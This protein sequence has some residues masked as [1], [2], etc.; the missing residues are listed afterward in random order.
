LKEQIAAATDP[1]VIETLEQKIKLTNIARV[2][3]S[4]L[5]VGLS[6]LVYIAYRKRQKA[7]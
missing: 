7:A 1:A 2:L 4:A 5:F 3:L 6:S